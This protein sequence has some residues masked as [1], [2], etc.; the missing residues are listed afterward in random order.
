MRGQCGDV[1]DDR[2]AVRQPERGVRVD[3]GRAIDGVDVHAVVHD[4]DLIA[5]DAVL[6]EDRGDEPGRRDEDVDVAVLP[7]RE[8]VSLQMEVHAS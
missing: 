8:G 1:A 2:C 6:F 5:G 4:L 3:D 7:A